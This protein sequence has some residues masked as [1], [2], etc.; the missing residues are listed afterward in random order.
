MCITATRDSH[1]DLPEVRVDCTQASRV[2]NAQ[3]VI[4]TN[5]FTAVNC[6]RELRHQDLPVAARPG[7]GPW[8]TITLTLVVRTH[9][10]NVISNASLHVCSRWHIFQI[11]SAWDKSSRAHQMTQDKRTFFLF[12]VL[13]ALR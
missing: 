2:H 11:S 9:N 10:Y 3:G 8:L 4:E 1:V 12:T 6:L 13:L 5:R 7:L